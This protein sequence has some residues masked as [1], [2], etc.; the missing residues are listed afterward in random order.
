GGSLRAVSTAGSAGSGDGGRTR[1]DRE[2][3]ARKARLEASLK[4]NIQR[5]K[6]Q[7]AA[8]KAAPKHEKICDDD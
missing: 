3:E 4:S 5:R 7:A 6:A 2:A 8:R 1:K